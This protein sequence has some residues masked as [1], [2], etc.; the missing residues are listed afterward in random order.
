MFLVEL[1]MIGFLTERIEIFESSRCL[2]DLDE[3]LSLQKKILFFFSPPAANR[4]CKKIHHPI[5]RA[6]IV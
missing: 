5:I 2:S 1:S 6:K 4:K 3:C